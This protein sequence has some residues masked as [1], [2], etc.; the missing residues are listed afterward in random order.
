MTPK[1][2][3]F[4]EEYLVDLNAT[5]AALRA[6]YS[7]KTARTIAAENLAKPNIQARITAL[8]QARSER[9]QIDA[10]QVVQELARVAFA[11]MGQVATWGPDGVTLHASVELDEAAQAVI[12]EVSEGPYGIKV[13]LFNKLDALG[14]LF[15][16]LEVEAL[17][18]KVERLNGLLTTDPT[19][20]G[21]DDGTSDDP[22]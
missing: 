19:S 9:T 16:H 5:Q 7:A 1:Q 10:D 15:Q 12:Q 6:G 8:K 22:E 18:R 20:R 3:R 4:I 13:K 14:K 17:E 21:G 11:H 2:Q